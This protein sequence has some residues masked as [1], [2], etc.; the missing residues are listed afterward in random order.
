MKSGVVVLALSLVNL[1]AMLYNFAKGPT[2][3]YG[4]NPLI[5]KLL[6]PFIAP[7][8]LLYF[9]VSFEEVPK[10]LLYYSVFCWLGDLALLSR[11]F[12]AN[13][14]GGA[15]FFCAHLSMIAYYNPPRDRSNILVL[16]LSL[17]S[18]LLFLFNLFP[19]LFKKRIEYAHSIFYLVVLN[20]ALVASVQRCVVMDPLSLKF[21]LAFI[22][23]ELFIMSDFYLVKGM[24]LRKEDTE[25]FKVILTYVLALWFI[26][27]SITM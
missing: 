12:I 16:V 11:K 21:I 27:I 22:G 6:K 10:Y 14:I 26:S 24:A 4:R 13:N 9:Y 25:N 3:F 17:P 19:L 7:L 18:T 8:M 15:C 23:H 2:Q 20:G 5:F 1:V